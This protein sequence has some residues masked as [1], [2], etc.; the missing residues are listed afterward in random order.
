MKRCLF[1]K[2]YLTRVWSMLLRSKNT[3]QGVYYD[4]NLCLSYFGLEN[5]SIGR[6][7]YCYGFINVLNDFLNYF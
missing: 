7:L 1:V 3:K 5:S 2:P 6:S 4:Y